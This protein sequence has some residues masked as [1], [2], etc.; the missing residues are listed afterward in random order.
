M[1]FFNILK[2]IKFSG[3]GVEGNGEFSNS[4][5]RQS[6]ASEIVSIKGDDTKKKTLKRQST[7]PVIPR[8]LT[9]T[10]YA[11]EAFKNCNVM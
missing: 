2:Q 7:T 6:S 9:R 1:L 5:R 11:K 4:L 3:S 10:E 8:R